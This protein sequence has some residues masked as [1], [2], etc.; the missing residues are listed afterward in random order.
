MKNIVTRFAPSP[1]GA[2][3]IGSLRTCMFNYFYALK[4]GGKCLFRLEDTDIDRYVEGA[5]EHIIES[6]RSLGI[7]FE[8]V[9]YSGPFED[10]KI[11][12]YIK[13]IQSKKANFSLFKPI[14]L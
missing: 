9:E 14:T 7:F 13:N 5:A 4:H 3:H 6:F 2:A 11:Y 10:N 12:P 8:D 1:T